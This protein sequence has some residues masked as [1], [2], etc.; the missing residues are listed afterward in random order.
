MASDQTQL[1]TII[2]I[3]VFKPKKTILNK[4]VIFQNVFNFNQ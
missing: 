1:Q 4:N 3:H 2:T